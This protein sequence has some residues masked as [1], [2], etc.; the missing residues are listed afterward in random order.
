MAERAHPHTHHS[1]KPNPTILDP[2]WRAGLAGLGALLVVIGIALWLAPPQRDVFAPAASSADQHG[3]VDVPSETVTG[4][5][6]GIG[7]LL[8]LIGANGRKLAS[9][10]IGDEELV[11]AQDVAASAGHAAHR[12]AKAEGMS[13]GKA[14]AAAALARVEAFTAARADPRGVDPESIAARAVD[15]IKS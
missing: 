1:A 3:K 12:K 11:W 14:L 15:E 9:V 5:L 7:A 6:A 4:V 10:K 2:R 13:D 8:I